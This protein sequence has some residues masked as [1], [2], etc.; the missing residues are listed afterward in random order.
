[1]IIDT[2]IG[3]KLAHMK[4]EIGFA[5]ADSV[6]CKMDPGRC[7]MEENKNARKTLRTRVRVRVCGENM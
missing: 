4:C 3:P 2:G 7:K 1:M 6:G 5:H